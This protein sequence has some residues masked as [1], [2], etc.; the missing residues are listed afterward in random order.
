MGR[1]LF[2]TRNIKEGQIIIDE[3]PF[4]SLN[5][6]PETNY[7]YFKSNIYPTLNE[8]TKQKILNMSD[9]VGNSVQGLAQKH[10]LLEICNNK[11]ICYDDEVGRILRISALNLIYFTGTLEISP[12][13]ETEG[14][15][16]NTISLINHSCDPN[17]L[18]SWV[19]G[20]FS[21]KQIRALKSIDKDEEILISYDKGGFRVV[22]SFG[23]RKFRQNEIMERFWF[24]CHCPECSLEGEALKE[25]ERVRQ[26]I[27][28][29][30][31]EIKEIWIKTEE[32]P[33]ITETTGEMGKQYFQTLLKRV[34][35]LHQK[36]MKLI[37]ELDL[38]MESVSELRNFFVVATLAKKCEISATD[39]E[40]LKMKALEY[41]KKYGDE[42]L[43][44][45]RDYIESFEKL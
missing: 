5:M 4:L 22:L 3:Y 26:E 43:Y 40:V 6:G 9:P 14:S 41:G 16:Y 19:M 18:T 34:L 12:Y 8:E 21:R 45:V 30:I 7:V 38:K 11:F 29:K 37:E 10:V 20:D 28:G 25:N 2:A 32:I 35:K 31:R 39:P 44:F 24:L 27:R 15:L 23:S 13:S 42:E 33:K 1:G 17:A 36:K